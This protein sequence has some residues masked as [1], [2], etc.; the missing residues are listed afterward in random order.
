[1]V[2]DKCSDSNVRGESTV[3]YSKT[4]YSGGNK[5]ITKF[6]FNDIYLKPKTISAALISFLFLLLGA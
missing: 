3:V 1:M 4:E 5:G 6:A 2:C